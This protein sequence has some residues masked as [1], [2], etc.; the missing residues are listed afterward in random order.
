MATTPF[1]LA[2]LA[3]SAVP[4]LVVTG[5][6][7]HTMDG[8]GEFTAAVLTTE[9][10]DVIVRV[11]VSPAAEVKQSAELLSI[12]ALAEGARSRLPFAV[13]VTLGMTRAGDTRAV[14][15]TFLGGVP[16]LLEQIEADSDLLGQVVDAIAAVHALPSGLARSGGLPVRDAAEV[17]GA[18]PAS[19]S[20]RQIPACCPRPCALVGM[21]CST[22]LGCGASNPQSCTA[23]SRPRCC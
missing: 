10:G 7:T 9:T 17:R 2:A 22:L 12:A 15:S 20:A 1:T 3:T 23:R 14:V 11:P 18:P 16:A 4:G 8:E 5:T 21:R 19:C 6:R 13:P